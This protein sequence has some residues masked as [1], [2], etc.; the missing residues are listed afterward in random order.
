VYCPGR[1]DYRL[2]CILDCRVRMS[3][4]EEQ[5]RFTDRSKEASKDAQEGEQSAISNQRIQSA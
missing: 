1:L 5:R 3:Y 2:V 4:V